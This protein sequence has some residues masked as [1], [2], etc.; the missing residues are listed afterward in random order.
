MC[1]EDKLATNSVCSAVLAV[2]KHYEKKRSEKKFPH[3]GKE[4][5]RT[6]EIQ[7][8]SPGLTGIQVHLTYKQFTWIYAEINLASSHK[9][10]RMQTEKYN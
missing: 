10:K 5:P 7:R 6:P 9:V 4:Q 2:L 3:T 8:N 1:P